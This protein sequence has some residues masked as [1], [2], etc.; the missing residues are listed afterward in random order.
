MRLYELIVHVKWSIF[1]I[2]AEFSE[3]GLG[4]R[5]SA[6]GIVLIF[7]RMIYERSTTH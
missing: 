7:N 2:T 1:V 4:I 3:I 5:I 6:L